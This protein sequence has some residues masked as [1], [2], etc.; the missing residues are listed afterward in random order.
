MSNKGRYLQKKEQR[1]VGRGKKIALIVGIVIAALILAIFIG[2]VCYYNYMLNLVQRPGEV[3]TPTMSDEEIEAMLNMTGGLEVSEATTEAPTETTVP[4]V[5]YSSDENI[6]NIML[7]GQAAREGED[8]RLSDTM[9]LCTINRNEK[10]LTLTSFQ[11][12]MRVVIPAYAGHS[13]GFS[14]MNVCYHLGS[15]WTGEV[16]GSMELLAMAVEQNFGVHVDNTVEVDF[17][18]FEKVVNLLGGV[19]LE[20]TQ[21]EVN[22]LQKNYPLYFEGF[23]EGENHL[24]GF[25]ALCY[26]RIRK[27]DSDFKRT[28]RQRTLITLL[29]DKCRSLSVTELHTMLTEVLPLITTDM[30]ND[31]I[32][33]YAMELLPL[34]AD[35]EIASQS[36]PFDGTW[37]STNAGTEEVPQYVIDC[38]L[39]K[40]KELL[41]E[42]IGMAESAE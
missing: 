12:D 19:D 34:V 22:Y 5:T 3:S 41:L 42:S 11:R 26:A 29:L 2:A 14:R 9:M 30:T 13:Q 33:N 7:V 37:W 38:N 31:E 40:N 17:E 15:Y 35:L 10:K 36:V 1:P 28:S 25:Q 18:M 24:D 8:Y 6:S 27:I 21:A 23:V 16:S 32:T 39:T 20:L 4:E